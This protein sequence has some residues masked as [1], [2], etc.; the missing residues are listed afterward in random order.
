MFNT[1]LLLVL[2]RWDVRGFFIIDRRCSNYF[3]GLEI[4]RM[5]LMVLATTAATTT[6]TATATTTTTTTAATTRK[7]QQQ[8]EE[9]HRQH[10]SD[11]AINLTYCPRV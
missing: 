9:Q 2:P 10:S 7:E 8:Q 3:G 11:V 6:T 4:A 1:C 5:L